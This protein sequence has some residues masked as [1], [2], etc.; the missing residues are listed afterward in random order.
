MATDTSRDS[1]R[2]L[3]A[4]AGLPEAYLP[5][6][7]RRLLDLPLLRRHGLSGHFV[8]MVEEA[9]RLGWFQVPGAERVAIT[10][11]GTRP[12]TPFGD[13]VFIFIIAE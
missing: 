8:G 11:R 1:L 10:F 12:G 6:L 13:A 4:G 5:L 7:E 3:L 9:F 2:N